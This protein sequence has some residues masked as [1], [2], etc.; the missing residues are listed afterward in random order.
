M[1]NTVFQQWL[2]FFTQ[3]H[4]KKIYAVSFRNSTTSGLILIKCYEGLYKSALPVLSYLKEGIKYQ[5][6]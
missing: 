5:D 2:Q 4:K 3:L 6:S 1:V